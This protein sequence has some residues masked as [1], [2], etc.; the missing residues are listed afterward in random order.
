MTPEGRIKKQVSKYLLTKSPSMWYW[1]VQDRFTCGI[2]DIIGCYGGL[3][4]GVE[5]K[6]PGCS[7]TAIQS[8]RVRQIKLAGGFATVATTLKQVKEL[9]GEVENDSR[10]KLRKV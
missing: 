1:C 10:F 4:F 5:L 2:L 8:W 9:I 3:F 7:A 6:K